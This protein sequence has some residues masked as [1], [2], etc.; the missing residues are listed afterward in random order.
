MDF[1]RHNGRCCVLFLDGHGLR[2]VDEPESGDPRDV[3]KFKS[4]RWK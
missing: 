2:K 3:L 4:K 1:E